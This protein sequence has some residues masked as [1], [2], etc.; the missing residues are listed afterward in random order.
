M[1]SMILI[2]VLKQLI[3]Y[4]QNAVYNGYRKESELNDILQSGY[5]NSPLDNKNVHWFVNDNMKIE[6]NMSFCF[7]NTKKDIIMTEEKL[8]NFEN[9]IFCRYCE[10]EITSAKVRDQCHLTG[11]YRG[12]AYNICNLNVEQKDSYFI[13][14][15][16]HNF[17]K[18]ESHLF[19]KSLVDITNDKVDFKILP[20]TNEEYISITYGCVK[21]MD[22][23][24]FLSSSLYI[25]IITLAY[26]SLKSIGNL[27]K[28]FV[29]TDHILI[30]VFEMG[31]YNR[32]IEDLEE[33]Y[34][35]D[36]EK[37]ENALLG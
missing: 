30:I 18:Y 16:L 27:K 28:E 21:F 19:F 15:I 37:V 11:A 7:K 12:P 33:D 6:N 20:K 8:E 17:S 34:P 25:L 24:R 3:F 22:S 13:P 5:Y 35:D 26:N 29:D 23:Y 2:L 10:K 36:I 31:E 14:V 1:K 32:T 9:N 4:K